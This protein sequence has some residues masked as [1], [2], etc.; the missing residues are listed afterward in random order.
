MLCTAVIVPSS[1][2]Y[3]GL[4]LLQLL[5]AEIFKYETIITFLS[6]DYT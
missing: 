3:K 5:Y 4:C 6:F 1:L 2:K